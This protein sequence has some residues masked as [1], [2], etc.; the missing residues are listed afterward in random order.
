MTS[1]TF[2]LSRSAL[3]PG[4]DPALPEHDA[5][6]QAFAAGYAYSRVDMPAVIYDSLRSTD[7]ATGGRSDS[8]VSEAGSLDLRAQNFE[9]AVSL[10]WAEAGQ[11]AALRLDAAWGTVDNIAVTEF[12]GTT[13]ALANWVDVF[14]SLRVA[15]DLVISVDGAKRAEIVT[16]SGDD[17][18]FVG[19]DSDGPEDTNFVRVVAGAGDDTITVGRAT[20]DYTPATAG[21][22]YKAAWTHTEL[23]GGAGDDVIAGGPS[24]DRI[25]GGSGIDTV[26]LHGPRDAYAVEFSGNAVIVR[27][28]RQGIARQD[29]ADRLTH[30]EFLQF[31]DMTL[32]LQQGGFGVISAPIVLGTALTDA[33]PHLYTSSIDYGDNPYD[34]ADFDALSVGARSLLSA[35]AAQP[36]SQALSFDALNRLVGATLVKAAAEIVYDTAGPEADYLVSIGGV[37]VGVEVSRAAAFPFGSPYPFAQAQALLTQKLGQIQE[38]N[39]NVGAA[40]RWEKQILHVFAVDAQATQTLADA[41]AVVDDA[42]K[43]DTILVITQTEGS[44]QFLYG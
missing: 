9:G 26:L 8:F 23:R 6:W 15:R 2:N 28:L 18:I 41:Y 20:E 13:L 24:A 7:P 42:L 33:A 27:D 16:G 44:D 38:A 10:D 11:A 1:I 35:P 12:T 39:A 29:G 43:A 32:A 30:V 40:D 14:V 3:A 5:L 19:I 25:D 31:T 21:G 17:S 4:W 36:L 34:A 37:R 22:G